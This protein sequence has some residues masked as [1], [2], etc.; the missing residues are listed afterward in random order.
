MGNQVKPHDKEY[1]EQLY[2]KDCN[3]KLNPLFI[4][5]L[6]SNDAVEKL[7]EHDDT[8]QYNKKVLN[9]LK[10]TVRACHYIIKIINVSYKIL[11]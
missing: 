9:N 11:I 10:H 4:C 8:L 2:H 3:L 7:I 5:P 1:D 6:V